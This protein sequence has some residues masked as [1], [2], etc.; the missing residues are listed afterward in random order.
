[1]RLNQVIIAGNIT[2]DAEA[3]TSTKGTDFI[4]LSFAYNENFKTQD[5]T[6]ESKAHFFEAFYTGKNC[7]ELAPHLTKG[8]Q[9]VVI[10]KLVLNSYKD[11]K[12]LEIM[13]EQIDI[14]QKI[15]KNAPKPE[16]NAPGYGNDDA[17]F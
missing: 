9:V 7:Y 12:K 5:G 1:M 15:D 14:I 4:R 16:N 2:R 10:G 6:W 8:T 3:K 17:P 13:A 11:Q